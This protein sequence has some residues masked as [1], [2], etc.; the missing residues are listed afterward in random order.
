MHREMPNMD[1]WGLAEEAHRLYPDLP[2]IMISGG[3]TAEI[4]AEQYAVKF[5]FL[6]FLEKP[7]SN[8]VFLEKVN[9]L[10]PAQPTVRE[11]P[12]VMPEVAGV[13]KDRVVV[14][15]GATMPQAIDVKGIRLPAT[16]SFQDAAIDGGSAEGLYYAGVKIKFKIQ[17]NNVVIYLDSRPG[18]ETLQ[19][20]IADKPVR[21]VLILGE[22]Q[23]VVAEKVQAVLEEIRQ[24]KTIAL[25]DRFGIKVESAMVNSEKEALVKDKLKGK[26]IVVVDDHDGIRRGLSY[27]LN[28]LAKVKDFPDPFSALEYIRAQPENVGLV[29]TDL[30]MP[31]TDPSLPRMDGDA[32]VRTLKQE[33]PATLVM[34]LTVSQKE[35]IEQLRVDLKIPV[36]YKEGDLT[37]TRDRIMNVVLGQE[38]AMT[39]GG[40][41]LNVKK[42]GLDVTKEGQGIRMTL[43]PAMVQQFQSGDFSGVAPVILQITPISGPA[44]ILGLKEESAILLIS[45]KS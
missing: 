4:F 30:N 34:M 14:A 32:F 16:M 24:G 42:M 23:E 3:M 7:V 43:D 36:F 41:D 37:E 11:N 35:V 1:G 8:D 19:L 25:L 44:A 22:T 5:P 33:F 9:S 28:D 20:R 38:A 17:N 21:Q 45:A 40:I 12:A 6:H 26:V 29:I 2:I 31:R 18:N 39:N 13:V 10:V 15:E 27:G